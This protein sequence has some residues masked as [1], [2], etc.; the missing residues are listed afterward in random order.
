MNLLELGC[1]CLDISLFKT[2]VD[3]AAYPGKGEFAFLAGVATWLYGYYHANDKIKTIGLRDFDRA[4][5]NGDLTIALKQTLRFAR[6]GFRPGYSFPSGDSA[7]AFALASTAGAAYPAAAPVFFLIASLTAISRLYLRVHYVWDV[8]GGALI[9]VACGYGSARYFMPA[10]GS[11]WRSFAWLAS[12]IPGAI[13]ILFSLPFFFLVER[14]IA[15][16]KIDVPTS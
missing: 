7:T 4:S 11:C 1:S 14:E 15:R 16:H 3:V 8:I 10:R 12:W 13:L 9:G 6:P 5:C 2:L